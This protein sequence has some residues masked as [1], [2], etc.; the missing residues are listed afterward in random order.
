[1]WSSKS[2]RYYC[3]FCWEPLSSAI[4]VIAQWAH[5]QWDHDSRDRVM[6]RLNN[7]GC[8]LLSLT[9]LQRYWV[10]DFLTLGPRYGI[11]TQGDQPLAWWHRSITLDHFFWRDSILSFIWINTYFGNIFAFPASNA[12]VKTPISIHSFLIVIHY[13]ILSIR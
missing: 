11:I 12:S 3:P 13:P 2:G 1:M 8:Y 6:H 9:W 5:E 10:P 7:T 4:S